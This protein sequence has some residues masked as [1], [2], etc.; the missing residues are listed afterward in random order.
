MMGRIL[1]LVAGSPGGKVQKSGAVGTG[2]R[3]NIRGTF[4]AGD[5]LHSQNVRG[6]GRHRTAD[7]LVQ[8]FLWVGIAVIAAPALSGWQWVTMVSPLFV[9]VLLT[10]VSGIPLLER[11]A[12][13]TLG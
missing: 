5:G 13:S 11:Q 1:A 7:L 2:Q 10:R 9:F 4:S 3:K 8:A 12:P 6:D